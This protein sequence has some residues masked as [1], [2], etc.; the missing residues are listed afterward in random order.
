LYR[1]WAITVLLLLQVNLVAPFLSAWMAGS[2]AALPACCRRTGAHG[3]SMQHNPPQ[4]EAGAGWHAL[5]KPCAAFPAILSIPSS[6]TPVVLTAQLAISALFTSHPNSPL[7]TEARGR[8]SWHRSHQKRGPPA[9][10][11]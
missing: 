11:C 10:S 2:E 5:S 6:S 7:Q 3:C 8:V 4:R 1:A 9:F